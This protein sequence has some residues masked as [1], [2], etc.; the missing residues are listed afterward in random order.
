MGE[1]CE[2]TYK[3]KPLGKSKQRIQTAN[4]T[5]DSIVKTLKKWEEKTVVKING[6]E[7]K[8]SR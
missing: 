1:R 5:K 2:G 7:I 4:K 8:K 3:T 6:R